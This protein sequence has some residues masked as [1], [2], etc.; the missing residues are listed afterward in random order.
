MTLKKTRGPNFKKVYGTG[1]KKVNDLVV[2]FYCEGEDA[3]KIGVSVSKRVGKAVVRNR[4][5]RQ[6]KEA[7]RFLMGGEIPGEI[8][9][10]ARGKAAFASYRQIVRALSDVLTRMELL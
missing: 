7:F 2:L 8:V 4:L 9:I 5:K 6:I 1:A 3:G 10:V